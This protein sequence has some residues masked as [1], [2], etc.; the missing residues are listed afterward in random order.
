MPAVAEIT[1][2]SCVAP[3]I[4]PL[5][6]VEKYKFCDPYLYKLLT[7]LMIADSKSYTVLHPTITS[8]A[9][10]EFLKANMVLTS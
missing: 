2:S 6:E 10:K 9:R 5:T 4:A 1:Q 8:D 7:L 3:P